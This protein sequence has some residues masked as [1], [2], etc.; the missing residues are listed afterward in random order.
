MTAQRVETQKGD[1]ATR[2]D[3]ERSRRVILDAAARLATVE[4]L[5]GMSIGRLAE[6]T[7]MSKSGLYAHFGSKEDLQLATVLRAGEIFGTD[8]VEP[9]L[10]VEDPV[11][12]LLALGEAFLAHVERRVFPGGCFFASAMAEFDTHPGPVKELITRYIADWFAH[13]EAAAREAQRV[14]A[15]RA[16]ED[17][18]QLAF[19]LD[20]FL[21]MGNQAFLMTNSSESIERGLRA[22][23]ERVQRALTSEGRRAGEAAAS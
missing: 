20:A 11:A 16:D 10:A 19:E 23:R 21:T 18:T 4:G 12:R 8:I 6:H 5:E 22:Y 17:L 13:L 14:G 7:G 2:S 9:A 1:R 15:I 3:G